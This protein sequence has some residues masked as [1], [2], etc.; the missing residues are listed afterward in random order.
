[1]TK[2]RLKSASLLTATLLIL[3]L[4]CGGGATPIPTNTEDPLATPTPVRA[5]QGEV[6]QSLTSQVILSGL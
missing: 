1:M 6:L 3:G 4:G 2:Y 5:T